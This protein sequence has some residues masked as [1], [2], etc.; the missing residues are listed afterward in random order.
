MHGVRG[1]GKFNFRLVEGFGIEQ[2]VELEVLDIGHANIVLA[3]IQGKWVGSV[4]VAYVE[5]GLVDDKP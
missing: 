2:N 4:F 1:G 5:K 3:H